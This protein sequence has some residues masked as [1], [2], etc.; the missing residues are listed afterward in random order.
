MTR[1]SRP[2][3]VHALPVIAAVAL[4]AFSLFPLFG[5]IQPGVGALAALVVAVGA[6]YTIGGVLDHRELVSTLSTMRVE[7]HVGT[8]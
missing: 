2:A 1:R 8:V 3:I 6:I 5:A 7:N 4:G